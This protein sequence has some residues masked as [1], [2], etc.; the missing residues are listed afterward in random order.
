M[1]PSKRE[2][3]SAFN[4]ETP[5]RV[6]VRSAA[7]GTVTT[8]KASAV[9]VRPSF[10]SP[11][12]M[13]LTMRQFP[14][15]KVEALTYPFQKADLTSSTSRFAVGLAGKA[16]RH[17]RLVE[18]SLRLREKRERSGIR[19][20]GEL[21]EGAAGE[22]ESFF[23]CASTRYRWGSKEEAS[24]RACFAPALRALYC[25]AAI[26]TRKQEARYHR[27]KRQWR[28]GE[29]SDRGRPRRGAN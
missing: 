3:T 11:G 15:P 5:V 22:L 17:G 7:V 29:G 27:K 8:K 9:D 13:T 24:S 25:R 26:A 2:P 6:K 21:R 20:R 16:G 4:F 14:I 12:S 18:A 28:A 19:M 1:Q 10:L 23:I